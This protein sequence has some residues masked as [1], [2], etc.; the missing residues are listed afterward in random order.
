MQMKKLLLLTII[1]SSLYFSARILL[2]WDKP[3]ST[4][5]TR[6]AVQVQKGTSLK[7]ISEI[8][9]EREL[10]RDSLAFQ[11]FIKWNNLDTKLQAGEYIIQRNLTFSEVAE[12][13]QHGKSSEI[14]VTIPEGSTIQ[15]IDTILAKKSLIEKGEFLNCASFCELDFTISNLEG[16]LFPSTYFV[17][18]KTFVIKNFIQRLHREFQKKIKSF[19]DDIASS[20]RT[21][22]EVIIVA[23]M[24]EREAANDFEMPE[25]ADII[26]KRLDNNVHLGIDATTRYEKN[27]WKSPLYSEDFE[28]DSPYNTR[29]RRGLP[30][31]AISNPGLAALNAAVH[32]KENPYWYYLHDR[33]GQ[34]HFAETL[35]E[36]N[37]YKRQYLN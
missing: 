36:H 35:E 24:I 30:P 15:Q 20:G 28:K 8:L 17:N 26:W 23:S 25:I 5:E 16:F 22:N 10:I 12:V 6:V 29:K 33:N 34:V 11:L 3:N 4:S 13:L 37:R 19:R 32:P 21:L 2:V 18:P 14:K 7:S 1:F 9:Y 27:D 31:T